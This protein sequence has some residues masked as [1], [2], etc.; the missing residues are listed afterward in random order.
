M[1]APNVK[2]KVRAVLF[3]FN[4]TMM[5]D[6]AI[7]EAVWLEKLRKAG[8][9]PGPKSEYS[10]HLFGCDNATI[11]G[12]Y[13]GITDPSEIEREAYLKEAEYRRRCAADTDVYRL[14]DGCAEFL[15][16]LKAAG[17]PMTIATGSDRYN[18]EFY[19]SSPNLNL[20]KWFDFDNVV[21]DNGT[22]PGKPAP[23]GY[24]RAAARL[25]ADPSECIVFEDS[26]S[27]VASAR[28]A[29]AAYVVALGKG[30]DAAK[31]EAV[32]GV[33]AAV[34]DFLNYKSFPGLML[35]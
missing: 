34:E 27:G 30:V 28:A 4:G 23:D 11:L 2:K 33:D 19:F 9:D 16:A 15:D 3:D 8:I 35:D 14:V 24:I 10:K 25:G 22:F 17:Y 18:V 21:Y 1:N 20:G 32:G 6:S 29:G 13:F 7:H 5:Y 31:F 26:Y 12:Y